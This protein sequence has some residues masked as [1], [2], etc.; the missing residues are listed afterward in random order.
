VRPADARAKGSER[1]DA[2]RVVEE[3]CATGRIIPADRDI[4]LGQIAAARTVGEV[5][6]VVRDLRAAPVAAAEP[7]RP[8]Q[9]TN[10]AEHA[11]R[12]SPTT[13]PEALVAEVT[14]LATSS[15]GRVPT[16][17]KLVPLVVAVV[18]IGAVASAVIGVVR[19]VHQSVSPTSPSSLVPDARTGR[20]AVD[21][22]S[23]KGYDA[24]VRTIKHFTGS[25][26]VYDAVLYPGY[27]VLQLPVDPGTRHEELYRWDGDLVSMGSLGS[28]NDRALDLAAIDPA[29]L[30]RL[31]ER[32]RRHL[33]DDPSSWYVILHDRGASDP[34]VIYAYASN[35]YG[36]GGYLSATIKGKVTRRIT[37]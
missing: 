10:P 21:V 14:R 19:Q 37:W 22:L 7:P 33:V 29:V 18:V 13:S 8:Y 1:K 35:K 25:T 27:A 20:P 15:P 36:E 4:R 3:A 11:A 34:S 23:T 12:S 9:S 6:L 32:A 24:M 17:L 16:L 5:D 2:T 28:T 26:K 31:S 30:V